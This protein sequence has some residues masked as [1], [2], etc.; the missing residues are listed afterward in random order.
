M[1]HRTMKTLATC[2]SVTTGL[3]SVALAGDAP[4]P[5]FVSSGTV[6]IEEGDVYTKI[7]VS[8]DGEVIMNG[9]EILGEAI[10]IAGGRLEINGGSVRLSVYSID[11]GS[12]ATPSELTIR[13]GELRGGTLSVNNIGEVTIE[14]EAFFYDD[15]RDGVSDAPIATPGGERLITTEDPIWND[16]EDLPIRAL[17]WIYPGGDEETANVNL[18]GTSEGEAWT[19]SI[20][21]VNVSADP[22]DI[23]GDG[24]VDAADLA[25]LVS[26]WGV[27]PLDGP[28]PTNINGD[29]VTNAADLAALLAAWTG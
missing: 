28:C 8:G 17:R 23:T 10:A 25:A 2:V 20:R 15:D 4:T 7:F 12:T 16:A 13:G 3:A 27:C 14:A 5:L 6:T 1:S 22:A 24:S 11:N 29:G 18:L 21:L 19:G 26:G 9:G